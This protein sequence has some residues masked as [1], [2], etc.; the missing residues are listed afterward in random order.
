M[1]YEKIQGWFNYQGFYDLMIDKFDNAQFVEIGAWKGKSACYMGEKLMEAKK[2]IKYTVI[3]NFK[4]NPESKL[5]AVDED[6]INGTLYNTFINNIKPLKDYINVMRGDSE[7]LYVY[8]EDKSIDFLFIDGSHTYNAVKKDIELWL[9]K[10]KTIISGHD[11][12]N[13]EVKMAVDEIFPNHKVWGEG[14]LIWY[15]EL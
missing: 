1:I 11:Y 5:H 15:V 12:D 2:N 7:N 10:V 4:G 6:I 3:D 9:P 8:W 13:K 14:C